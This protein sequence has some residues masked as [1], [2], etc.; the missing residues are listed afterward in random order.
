MFVFSCYTGFV[1]K[2]I[3]IT[4]PQDVAH[5]ARKKAAED[6]ISLSRLVSR[7]LEREMRQSDEYWRAYLAWQNIRSIAGIDA[8]NRLSRE[9][10]HARRR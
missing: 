9:E 1:L 3:T 6:D 2:N 5:W 4:V 8:K 10:A 7:M